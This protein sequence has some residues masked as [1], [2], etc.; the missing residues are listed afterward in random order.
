MK[1]I[2]R[3]IF[4]ELITPL[5]FGI[6]AFA[7]I[8]IGTD[9]LF[10]LIEYYNNYGV[11]LLTLIQLF[12][13]NLPAIIVITFPMA[14]LL[15]T[16]MSYGRLSGDNEITALR[17]G[18]ISVYRLV[19]PAL[20]LGILMTL[21]TIGVNEYIVPQANYFNE[22]IV[23]QF[24]HGERMPSTQH[25]LFLT[26]MKDGYPDYVLYT[27]LYDGETGVMQGIIFQ[28]YEEG[29]PVTLIQAENA[30]YTGDRWKFLNGHIYRLE[31]GERIP[32]LKFEEYN[33]NNL[34]YTPAQMARLDKKIS[35]MNFTELIEYINLKESQGND[36]NEELVELHQRISIPFA[37]FI[38]A[39]LAATLGIQPQRSG[40]SATGMG[41]SIVVIF[42]YYTLMTVGS[43]LGERGTIPPFLGAWLQNFVFMI[44]GGVMLYRLGR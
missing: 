11:E 26:P 3:Y 17:A 29:K 40:G 18:G 16:I 28:D 43:A 38:F 35:D 31:P 4:I 21:F 14:T 42:I 25:D 20:F 15:G 9:L 5:L 24:K 41:L 37:S 33:V 6:A 22:Q 30:V 13:L 34:N 44:T 2:Y 36:V 39:L 8:F 1:I 12:F 27:K 7:A 10:E 23:Y 32:D 19:I